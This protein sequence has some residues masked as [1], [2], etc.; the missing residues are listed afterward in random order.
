MRQAHHIS[1][2]A[3]M[4]PDLLSKLLLMGGSAVALFC[5]LYVLWQAIQ[6]S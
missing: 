4:D 2:N 5:F 6:M 3:L 1:R